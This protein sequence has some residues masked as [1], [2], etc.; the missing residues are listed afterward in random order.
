[1]KASDTGRIGRNGKRPHRYH[2]N[3]AIGVGEVMAC[4]VAGSRDCLSP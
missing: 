3:L 4:A 2:L 1:M